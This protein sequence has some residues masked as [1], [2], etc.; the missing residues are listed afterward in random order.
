MRR[1]EVAEATAP[2]TEYARDVSTEPL[3]LTIDGKPVAA[4]VPI[5]NTDL[6]TATL[7][8]HPKFLALLERSRAQLKRRGGLSS[9]E[10]RRRLGL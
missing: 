9:S 6:E 10:M 8:T 4:L 3:I 7:S 5:A 1:L 2:L